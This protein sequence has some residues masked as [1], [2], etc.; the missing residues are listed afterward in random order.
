[1]QWG[2]GAT[3]CGSPTGDQPRCTGGEA[4]NPRF[5]EVDQ[6]ACSIAS[7]LLHFREGVS[8]HG[9]FLRVPFFLSEYRPRLYDNFSR[10]SATDRV[11]RRQGN[12]IP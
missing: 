8:L 1:M 5:V 3:R 11:S 7:R 10:L 6:A 9:E 12:G 2:C 4:E